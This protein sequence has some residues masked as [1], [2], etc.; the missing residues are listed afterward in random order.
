MG[1]FGW[2]SAGVIYGLDL[3]A[4]ATNGGGGRGN[5]RTTDTP[6]GSAGRM[7]VRT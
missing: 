7:R 1:C 4:D 2:L 3:L 6:M 5:V